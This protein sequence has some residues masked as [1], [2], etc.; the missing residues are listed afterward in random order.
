MTIR[1]LDDRRWIVDD[2]LHELAHFLFLDDA[3]NF[4]TAY[5]ETIYISKSGDRREWREWRR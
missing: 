5:N 3:I 4:C 1:P 2:G